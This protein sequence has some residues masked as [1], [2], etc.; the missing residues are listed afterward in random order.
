MSVKSVLVTGDLSSNL[1]YPIWDPETSDIKRG[2][3]AISLEKVIVKYSKDQPKYFSFCVKTN[4]VTQT[5][6]DQQGRINHLNTC[7][8]I[9]S[10]KGSD[11][12]EMLTHNVN[13][14][15]FQITVP[16]NELRVFIESPFD[17]KKIE[18]PCQMALY[19]L[20]KRI[21]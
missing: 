10:S 18:K 7:L 8:G 5:T 12:D 11:K 17:G 3:W 9:F 16:A 21:Q 6:Q 13:Q 15:W 4:L 20:Y 19:F 14:T 2:V 1:S